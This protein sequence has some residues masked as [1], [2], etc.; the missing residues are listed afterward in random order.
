MAVKSSVQIDSRFREFRDEL[1]QA[2]DRGLRRGAE[3]VAEEARSAPTRGY[4]IQEVLASVRAGQPRGGRRGGR[5]ID[6]GPSD[7]RGGWFEKGTSR[8]I[9]PVGYLRR[10][11]RRAAE[12]IVD[13]IAR[14]TR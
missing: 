1:E 5:E 11:K 3:A 8:G 12:E 7:F 2:V 14:E 10:A 13:A 6:V 9:K 4:R